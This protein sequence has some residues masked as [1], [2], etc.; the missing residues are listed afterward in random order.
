ML[1]QVALPQYQ[2]GLGISNLPR[3]AFEFGRLLSGAR[4]EGP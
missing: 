1:G 3:N 2:F 4:P